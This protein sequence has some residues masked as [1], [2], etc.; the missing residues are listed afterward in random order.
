MGGPEGAKYVPGSMS[1]DPLPQLSPGHFLMSSGLWF[2]FAIAAAFL[3]AAVRLRRYR[4][5]I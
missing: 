1:M 5:P 4:D 2:G 3:A